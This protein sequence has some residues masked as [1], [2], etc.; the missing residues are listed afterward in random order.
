MSLGVC[1]L[2]TKYHLSVFDQTYAMAM[3]Q[4]DPG[5]IIVQAYEMQICPFKYVFSLSCQ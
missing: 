5:V 1:R 4:Y 3:L 2:N